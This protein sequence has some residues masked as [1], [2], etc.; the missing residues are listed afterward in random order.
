MQIPEGFNDSPPPFPRSTTSSLVYALQGLLCRGSRASSL[1]CHISLE[2]PGLGS[3]VVGWCPLRQQ[4]DGLAKSLQG[5]AKVTG[6][7]CYHSLQLQGLGLF[8]LC[9]RENSI[10]AKEG[11]RRMCNWEQEAKPTSGFRNL[12][13]N[14]L[15][16]D[17]G[18]WSQI[19]YLGQGTWGH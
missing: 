6:L 12:S 5:C 16:W 3:I 15:D 2:S 13:Q 17:M 14:L 18:H 8:Q 9:L 4:V 10:C 19:Q 7:S 1:T 11:A